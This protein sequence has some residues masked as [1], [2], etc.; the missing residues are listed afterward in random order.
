[1]RADIYTTSEY[2]NCCRRLIGRCD[3]CATL[4]IEYRRLYL[5]QHLRSDPSIYIFMSGL[6][7][8]LRYNAST[9]NSG[10][11][12]RLSDKASTVFIIH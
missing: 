7:V 8:A 5:I 3:L 1:M 11:C 12:G 4:P 2:I 6:R 9:S 10:K